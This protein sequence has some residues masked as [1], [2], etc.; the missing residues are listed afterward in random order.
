MKTAMKGKAMKGKVMKA[1]KVS[2]IAKGVRA[3]AAVFTGG[4]A[5]TYTGLKKTDLMKSKTGKIV[6]RKS[7]AAGVKA[8]KHIKGWT[9]AVQKARKDLGV[10]GFVA[11]KKGTALYTA[12]KA[13]YAA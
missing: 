9:A 11:V 2:Q 1:K 4:K 5:K 10:K 8:Y 6:T 13:I 7:H 3:R 12:A